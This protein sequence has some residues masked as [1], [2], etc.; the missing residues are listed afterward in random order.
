MAGSAP[1][2]NMQGKVVLITGANVGIGRVA[3]V[4]LARTGAQVVVATRSLP[5]TQGLLDEVKAMGGPGS[6]EWLELDL[7]DFASVHRAADAFLAKGLPLHVLINNAG[8]AAAKGLTASGFE[9]AFGINHMGHFLLTQRLLPCLQA[10]APARIV[11]VASRAHTRVSGIDWQA[12]REPTRSGAGLAEYGV[13]KLANVWFS[14]ELGRR[15]GGTGVHT[16]ALHPGVVATEIW[17]QLPKPLAVM[18]KWFMISPEEG[19]ATTL[20]CATSDAVAAQTGLYYDQCRPKLPS[21]LGQDTALAAEL[22]QRSE[23]WVAGR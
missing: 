6:A 5:R 11:T 2:P 9:M 1:L 3:A 15:L 10:S 16:Y 4:A 7:A 19:V 14:A 22:W 21:R 13:S 20:Y 18:A 8:V 17:R 12:V 23:A